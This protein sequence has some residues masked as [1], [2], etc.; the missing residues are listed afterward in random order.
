MTAS[1]D[2]WGLEGLLDNEDIPKTFEPL[3]EDLRSGSEAFLPMTRQ[4][5]DFYDDEPLE[6]PALKHCSEWPAQFPVA[7]A[8]GVEEQADILTRFDIS[9]ERFEMLK[10]LPAFRK[11]VAEA[12]K[13]IREQGHTFKIKCKGIA[14]DFLDDLYLELQNPQ[15]G[16]STKVDVFKYLTRMGGLEPQAQVAGTQSSAPQV[17]IQINL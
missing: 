9:P 15:V 10:P 7:L 6:A 3:L 12:Q 4:D 11:A 1:H 2:S 5:T 16:L 13:E 17:N 8:L 14:E